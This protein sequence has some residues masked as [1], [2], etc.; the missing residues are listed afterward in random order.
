MEILF[1]ELS[2][3][4]QFRN[5]NEFIS[6]GL[7]KFLSMLKNV[8]THAVLLLKKS[9]TWSRNIS[10]ASTLHDLL[11]NPK[12]RKEDEILRF[13]SEIAKLTK[14]PFWDTE[15]KQLPKISYLIDSCDYSGTSIAEACERDKML[16]SFV[17]SHLSYSPID[18][19]KDGSTISL[20]NL[21]RDG[22]LTE[23]LWKERS[24]SF[25]L[26]VKTKYSKGKLDFSQ[27]DS[28]L[29]FKC[30]DPNDD[31]RYLDS[32]ELIESL[33]WD[34]I[35][36]HTGLD[37]KQYHSKIASKYNFKTYKFR[38]TEKMRCHGYRSGDRFVVVGFETDHK[39]SDIG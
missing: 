21:T 7:T 30:I 20:T 31:R 9:D 18:I 19:L 34:A 22:E 2:L 36:S 12:F 29:G 17:D 26:Y 4:G 16:V 35:Y 38:V 15:S 33:S 27:V 25:E 11:T 37:Y 8:E 6:K 10:P 32:F 13:K 39:L 5:E 1:N 14:E 3:S 23:Y 28:G 24:I